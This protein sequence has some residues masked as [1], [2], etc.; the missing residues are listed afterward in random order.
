MSGGVDSSVAAYLLKEQGYDVIGVTMEIWKKEPND[1]LEREGGCCG[2]SAAEDAG[3]VAGILGIPHYV[4]NFRDVFQEKVIDYFVQEYQSGHTPNPC[5]ACN[6]YVKWEALLRRSLEIGADYIATGHYARVQKLPGGRYTIVRSR[7]ARKDQSYA[8][9]N[10]TQEQLSHTLL[11]VG[12]YEKEKIREIAAM[13]GLQVAQ[14]P[15]SQ[16][17]C[18]IPDNDYKRFLKEE[19]GKEPQEGNFVDKAGNVLGKHKG[20]THYTIGQRK[21]LNLAFGHPVFVTEL[22][23]ETNEVVIGGSEDVFTEELQ[24]GHLHCMAVERFQ[25]GQ[26]MMAKIRYA[27]KGQMCTVKSLGNDTMVIV[28]DRKVRAVTP[29]QAVV[30]YQEDMVLGGGTIVRG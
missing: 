23:P 5:I 7:S 19:M 13:Q 14:K 9:Y 30:F 11:P 26:R 10:L 15:D 29:G 16:D 17:I 4:M 12:D 18:F 21:G 3:R 28:F 24:A 6:R 22:R 2:M 20:I 8:L 25:E 1:V 27:D